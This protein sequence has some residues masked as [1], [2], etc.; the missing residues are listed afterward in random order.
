MKLKLIIFLL[1]F[2]CLNVL[3]ANPKF[4]KYLTKT[5]GPY[6]EKVKGISIGDILKKTITNKQIDFDFDKH[7]K[8]L[9]KDPDN[10][11]LDEVKEAMKQT[12]DRLRVVLNSVED[13]NVKDELTLFADLITAFRNFDVKNLGEG[14]E[15]A[16]R[17]GMVGFLRALDA[18]ADYRGVRN[19]MTT[20]S[21]ALKDNKKLLTLNIFDDISVVL[22]G[23]KEKGE[24]AEGVLY[25]QFRQWMNRMGD[26]PLTRDGPGDSKWFGGIAEL[27]MARMLIENPK[28]TGKIIGFNQ[29][30]GIDILIKNG[31]TI[32]AFEIKNIDFHNIEYPNTSAIIKQ[33][34]GYP[35]HAS[36]LALNLDTNNVYLVIMGSD[37]TIKTTTF[38]EKFNKNKKKLKK[39]KNYNIEN[40]I[41]L[42]ARKGSKNDIDN[43]SAIVNLDSKSIDKLLDV[44]NN[45]G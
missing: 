15:E 17:K 3:N 28:F 2:C 26:K 44:V 19:L 6:L 13:T 36:K 30:E 4:D 38:I 42:E 5:F 31:N 21:N 29:N 14:G 23:F 16:L 18:G 33:I 39:M 11:T 40:I 37:S 27:K 45:G 8:S 25:P 24:N 9:L 12:E 34:D 43:L 41:F 1:I 20:L 10:A 22:K 32:K 35:T 7:W